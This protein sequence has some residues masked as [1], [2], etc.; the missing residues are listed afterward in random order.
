MGKVKVEPM[1]AVEFIAARVEGQLKW[2]R[3]LMETAWAIVGEGFSEKVVSVGETNVQELSWW[4]R[5]KYQSLNYSTWFMPTVSIISPN[6][7]VGNDEPQPKPGLTIDYGDLLHVDFGVTA[8]GMN[9]DTQHLGYVLRPNETDVPNGFKDGLKKANR[10]QDIVLDKMVPGLTGNEVLK[11]VRGQMEKE[12][13]EG[14]IYCHPI[15]D[16]GHAAG[17]V[18][19][20]TNLQDSV[21]VLGDLPILPNT[22]YSIELFAEHFVPERNATYKFMQEEDVYWKSEEEGWVWVYGRQEE[23]HLVR[24]VDGQSEVYWRVQGR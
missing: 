18:I 15:G 13:I 7:E 3:K 4:F 12:G 10:M 22:Y 8:L 11:L 19:G 21:P 24:P 16:W 17:A 23:F 9:T 2:Y 14:S 20:M 6:T 5:E 1:L